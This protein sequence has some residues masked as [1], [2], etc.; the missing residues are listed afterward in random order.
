MYWFS[1]F[2]QVNIG[3]VANLNPTLSGSAN[4]AQ[5]FGFVVALAQLGFV[6]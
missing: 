4:F 5:H 6:F 2:A 3:S 1:L